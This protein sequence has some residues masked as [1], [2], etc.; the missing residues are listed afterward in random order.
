MVLSFCFQSGRLWGVYPWAVSWSCSCWGSVG[1][2]VVLTR[3]AAMCAAAA[4]L[5]PAAVPN[6]VSNKKDQSLSLTACSFS[7]LWVFFNVF[8]VFAVYE[9]GKMAKSRNPP[10]VPLFPYYIPGV[11][12]VVSVAPSSHLDPKI[13]SVPSMENNLAGGKCQW[14]FEWMTGDVASKEHSLWQTGNLWPRRH[15]WHSVSAKY[16]LYTDM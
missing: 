5:T 15:P 3:A 4:V 16:W 9:A 7:S 12:A 11:P 1:A 2:S 10:Q 13:S 8:F 6:T 14:N